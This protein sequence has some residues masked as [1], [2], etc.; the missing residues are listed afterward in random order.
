MKK[1]LKLIFLYVP[2]C[3]VALSLLLVIC[4]KWLPVKVT[5]LMI[6][7]SVQ[8]TGSLFEA[9][10]RKWIPLED[11][12]KDLISSVITSEDARFFEHK[13]FDL[14]E[15]EKMQEKHKKKGSPL[16][17]CSTISQQ[18]AKN[19]FTWCSRTWVRKGLEAYYTVLI[20][21]IWGKRRIL[22]VYFNIVELGPG[23]YGAEAASQHY[24]KCPAS[25]VSLV[26]ASALACCLPNPL[27]RTPDW[28][29]SHM[30]SRRAEIAAISNQV[31]LEYEKP[32]KKK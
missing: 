30:P 24:F 10:T 19:C 12:S 9:A 11:V 17:G 26:N 20:E 6:K 15:L 5:P 22:E 28:V 2:L 14:V 21:T 27:K 29:K 7:R 3:F 23:I 16:R 13:G 8:G 1:I 18:T 32:A 25:K 4:G 31:R